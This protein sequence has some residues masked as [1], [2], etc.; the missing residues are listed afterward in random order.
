MIRF[1]ASDFSIALAIR[2]RRFHILR[3]VEQFPHLDRHLVDQ[4]L[5][6]LY[7][8]RLLLRPFGQLDRVRRCHFDRLSR[9]LRVR[10]Q[11]FARCRHEFCSPRHVRQQVLQ[12]LLHFVRA[13]CQPSDL[14]CPID[15][16]IGNPKIPMRNPFKPCRY[17][18]QRCDRSSQYR[19]RNNPCHYQ[20]A[21]HRHEHLQR[22]IVYDPVEL[23][24]R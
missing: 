9:L 17:L 11:F 3:R 2:Y 18:R 12:S 1:R 7:R 6:R 20:H 16:E 4:C 14:I 24:H 22:K 23:M 21:D 8:L 19:P 15:F 10:R 13:R 5:K